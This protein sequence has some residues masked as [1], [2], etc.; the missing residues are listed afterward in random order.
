ME[1]SPQE[2]VQ[3]LTNDAGWS[4]QRIATAVGTTQ[5]TIARIKSGDHTSQSYQLLDKLR[6]LWT[7]SEAFQD[8]ISRKDIADDSEV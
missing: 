5:P 6:Q 2:I 8:E 3:R 7:T 4:Q 1:L